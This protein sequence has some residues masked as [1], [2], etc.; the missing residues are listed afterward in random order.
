MEE[1]ITFNV[2]GKLV[3]GSYETALTAIRATKMYSSELE[4]RKALNNARHGGV[5]FKVAAGMSWSASHEFMKNSSWLQQPILYQQ[6]CSP[7]DHLAHCEMH[8]LYFGGCL[9]CPVCQGFYEH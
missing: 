5:A 4:L 9:G 1:P 3:R 7:S 8:K 6:G 2:W